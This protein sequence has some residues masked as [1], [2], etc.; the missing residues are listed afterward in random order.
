M[1]ISGIIRRVGPGVTSFSC[2]DRVVGMDEGGLF[3][4]TVVISDL[5]LA[6]IPD[7]LSF[8]D[9][10]T[11]PVCFGTVII[12]LIEIGQLEKHQVCISKM[13]FSLHD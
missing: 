2:G 7:N 1:E 10:A 9:A 13:F 3:S 4:S 5:L 8:E 6:R 11:I 12:S